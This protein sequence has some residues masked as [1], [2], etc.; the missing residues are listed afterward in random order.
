MKPQLTH[1]MKSF[2]NEPGTQEGS[3]HRL[4]LLLILFS[5]LFWVSYLILITGKFPDVPP[6]LENL[7]E[8]LGGICVAGIGWGKWIGKGG[9]GVAEPNQ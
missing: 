4:A 3:S 5:V 2:L 1:W 6:S 7:L 8:W 9:N